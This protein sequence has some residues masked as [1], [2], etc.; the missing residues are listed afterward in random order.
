MI[1]ELILKLVFGLI[2]IIIDLLPKFNLNFTGVSSILNT[3]NV[4]L[5]FLPQ[6]F[7][8]LLV[9]TTLFWTLTQLSW[10]AIEWLYKKIP[11]VD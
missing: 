9:G 3:I 11:G 10:G 7:F 4:G 2:G 6:G 1:L 8:P 5:S